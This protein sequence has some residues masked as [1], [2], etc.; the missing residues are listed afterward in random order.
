MSR[1]RDVSSGTDGV[2][3]AAIGGVIGMTVG[4]T[5]GSAGVGAGTGRSIVRCAVGDLV[6]GATG[7]SSIAFTA[8]GGG[9]RGTTNG[10]GLDSRVVSDH[11]ATLRMEMNASRNKPAVTAAA[12][13]KEGQRG[14]EGCRSS[15]FN[16]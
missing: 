7:A 9:R 1:A 6:G 11:G 3:G 13:P 5:I 16:P 2:I 15:Q 14:P 12:N 4:G 10:A 8:G